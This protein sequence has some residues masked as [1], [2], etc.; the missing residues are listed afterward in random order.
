M[1]L[2]DKHH[3]TCKQLQETNEKNNNKKPS[4]QQIARSWMFRGE[5]EKNGLCLCIIVLLIYITN[6]YKVAIE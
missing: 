1:G 2:D 3:H 6:F 4:D 5:I